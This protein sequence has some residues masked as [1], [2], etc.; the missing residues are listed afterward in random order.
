MRVYIHSLS[1]APGVTA[2]DD[3]RLLHRELP[4]S[5]IMQCTGSAADCSLLLI[6][7]KLVVDEPWTRGQTVT[8]AHYRDADDLLGRLRDRGL[9]EPVDSKDAWGDAS[10][11]ITEAVQAGLHDPGPW[12]V[13][14]RDGAREWVE[15]EALVARL[16]AE[17][18]P[19]GPAW[20]EH[21][22]RVGMSGVRHNYRNQSQAITALIALQEWDNEAARDA[23]LLREALGRELLY[24]HAAVNVA[25][26]LRV[27]PHDW[28][29][30]GPLY[31]GLS[32]PGAAAALSVRLPGLRADC[33]PSV[34]DLLADPA[35]GTA[36]EMA[37]AAL[38]G[39]DV[40]AADIERELLQVVP[41]ECRAPYAYRR[42]SFYRYAPD[43]AARMGLPDEGLYAVS[44]WRVTGIDAR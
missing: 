14:L 1:C 27:V 11:R 16:W 24:L 10:V 34:A 15:Q 18:R 22:R 19:D 39:D 35:L 38:A 9:V 2:S 37:A 3:E 28:S 6:A 29:D 23:S 25:A 12:L 20:S 7:D 5:G 36:R 41:R 4:G 33:D 40:P 13:A 21:L 17:A 32:P 8:E 26:T 30:F 31:A 44:A 43:L 42:V